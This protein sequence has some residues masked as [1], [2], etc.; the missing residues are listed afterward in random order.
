M[1]SSPCLAAI[2][3]LPLTKNTGT[4]R[5]ANDETMSVSAGS[6]C[7]GLM[8]YELRVQTGGQRKIISRDVVVFF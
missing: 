4:E 5:R 8:L 6:F 3:V 7:C 1:W 2:Q